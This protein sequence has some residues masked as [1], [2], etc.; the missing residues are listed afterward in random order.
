LLW[1]LG[2]LT[3]GMVPFELNIRVNDRGETSQF[4]RD[5]RSS[6]NIREGPGSC[7]YQRET[8]GRVW[9]SEKDL[10]FVDIG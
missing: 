1:G 8:S 3:S 5:L 4:Q 7:E 10:A 9:I 6:V 2:S